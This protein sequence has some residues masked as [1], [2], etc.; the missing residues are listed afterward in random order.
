VKTVYCISG[1]GADEKVFSR[2]TIEGYSLVYLQWLTPLKKETIQQYA[3]RMAEGIQDESPILAGVSFGGMMCIEISK[4]LKTEKVILISSI[5]SHKEMPAWMRW[6]GKF[7]LNKL[8]PLRPYKMLEPIENKRMGVTSKEDLA[9][10]RN[11]RK[12]VSQVYLDWAI[13]VILHWRNDWQPTHMYHIHGDKDKIFPIKKLSP[14]YIIKDAGHFMVY[15]KATEVSAL[16]KAIL[17]DR[18]DI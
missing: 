5:Q 18:S 1:L 9:I 11:Y 12:N 13:Q 15:N 4:F 3:R 14:T 10:V 16:V 8:I 2:L 7:R 6:S 17:Q